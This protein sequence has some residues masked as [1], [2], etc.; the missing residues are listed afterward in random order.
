MIPGSCMGDCITKLLSTAVVLRITPWYFMLLSPNGVVPQVRRRR[1]VYSSR[2]EGSMTPSTAGWRHV[3]QT[4]AKSVRVAPGL[5]L[6]GKM[7][8][9]EKPSTPPGRPSLP[10]SQLSPREVQKR[11]SHASQQL[12]DRKIRDSA[13]TQNFEELVGYSLFGTYFSRNDFVWGTSPYGRRMRAAEDS[14]N[15]SR[16]GRGNLSK[17]SNSEPDPRHFYLPA[18]LVR[19][20]DCLGLSALVDYWNDG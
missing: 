15:R 13:Y 6:V 9:D 20:L 1:T 16:G 7:G 5:S 8:K 10:V 11:K 19:L 17:P 2:T 4:L 12:L 3:R 14:L 18:L